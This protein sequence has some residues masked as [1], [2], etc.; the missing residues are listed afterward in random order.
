MITYIHDRSLLITRVC[1]RSGSD[2][3]FRSPLLM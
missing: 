2:R 3:N 1:E